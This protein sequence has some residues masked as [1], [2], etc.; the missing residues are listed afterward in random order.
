MPWTMQG[1]NHVFKVGV[2]FLGLG[3]YTK[4]N[5]DGILSFVHCSLQ[6]RKTL[7]W[8]VQI[9]GVRTPPT[10]QWLRPCPGPLASHAPSTLH[11]YITSPHPSS[12]GSAMRVLQPSM[13]NPT[14]A[15]RYFHGSDTVCGPGRV[16]SANRRDIRRRATTR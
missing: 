7:G 15:A 12:F 6:L 4:Q 16:A 14:L 3:Y 13:L 2:Q 8:S 1:R 10:P 11:A 9:L 5:T